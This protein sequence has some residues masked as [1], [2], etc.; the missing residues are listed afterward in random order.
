MRPADRERVRVEVVQRVVDGYVRQARDA[1]EGFLQR[2]VNDTLYQERRRLDQADPRSKR[3]K[4]ELALYQEVQRRLHS[5]AETTVRALLEQLATRFVDEVIGN[6]DD[7]VYRLSTTL[8]PPG[9][10]LLVN[11]MSP[12]RLLDLRRLSRSLVDQLKIQ[13]EVEQVQRLAQHGTVVVVPT[14]SSNLDSIV[15]GYAGYRIGLPPLLYGAGINL[16]SNPMISFFMHNLGAYKVDRKKTAKLYRAVLKEYTT[17]AL[18]LG[19]HQLFFPGGT[20]SRSGAIEQQLKKGLLGTVIRA[21]TNNLI[22]GREPARI[23]LAPCTL[24]YK[25][26]LEAEAL[27]RSHLQET[28][29]A[30]YIVEDD[31]FSR[32]RRVLNFLFNLTSLDDEIAVTWSPPLDVFGNRVDADGNSLDPRGRVVDPRSYVTRDGVPYVDEQRDVEY[33]NELADAVGGAFLR[34]NVVMTTHVVARAVFELLRRRNP[35][36]DLYRLL[37]TGGDAPSFAMAE[38]HSEVERLLGELGRSDVTRPR[39]S[40]LLQAGDVQEIVADA[41]RHFAIYH[42]RPAA[43]RRGDRLFHE[44]RNLLCYYGNRLDGYGLGGS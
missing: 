40:A 24:S 12:R 26:V 7:R 30:S 11:A 14:H 13:G 36:H 32:P 35:T 39:L 28:G 25:L 23:Y 4:S 37:Q 10:S 9:L 3:T 42:T 8:I 38:V 44:H 6:L 22:A 19:Y 29:K 17:C 21:Y 15:L 41:L 5:A 2:L 31:E 33:T 16:F 20:R 27:I 1:P 18:E 34:D 43:V